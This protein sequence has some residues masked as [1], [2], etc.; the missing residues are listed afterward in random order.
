MPVKLWDPLGTHAIPEHLCSA[1]S[2]RRGTISSVFTFTLSWYWILL[3][4]GGFSVAGQSTR[5]NLPPLLLIIESYTQFCSRQLCGDADRVDFCRN[6]TGV[7]TDVAVV[8]VQQEWKMSQD[9]CMNGELETWYG[10]PARGMET[11]DPQLPQ[12][13]RRNAEMKTHFTVMLLLLC[14]QWQKMNL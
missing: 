2:L 5:I 10:T 7:K 12:E 13:C 8:E 4:H 6:P 9:S 11:N 3:S 14:I 1:D